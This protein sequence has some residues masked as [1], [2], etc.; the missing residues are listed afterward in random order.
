VAWC[1][2]VAAMHQEGPAEV[3]DSLTGTG[4]RAAHPAEAG[5]PVQPPRKKPDSMGSGHRSWK[6]TPGWRTLK[7]TKVLGTS[8]PK[9]G[10]TGEIRE[11]QHENRP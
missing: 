11:Q 10:A 1:G 7:G 6:H 2:Q 8:S 3:G 4:S 5:M 9:E